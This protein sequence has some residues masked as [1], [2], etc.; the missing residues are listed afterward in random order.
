MN[1]ISCKFPIIETDRL[2]LRELKTTDI[3]DLFEI[4]SSESVTKYYGKYPMENLSE[5]EDLILKFHKAF[6]EQK[7]IRWGIELKEPNKII[8]TCGFH[9]WNKNHFRAEVGYELGE[10]FWNKGYATEAISSILI[11]GFEFMDLKRIEAIVYPENNPSEKLLLN[12]GFEH[13][14]L[15]KKYANFR[16]RQ[17]DLNIF[18]ILK[19]N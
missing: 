8:G 4:L 1:E 19:S 16:D 18:A 10:A 3:N 12:L 11:Y 2:I 9:C 13:E 7:S 17:Q 5:A 14:G 6:Y 15:L